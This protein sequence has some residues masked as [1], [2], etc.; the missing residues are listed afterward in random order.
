[1]KMNEPA[2]VHIEK[3]DADGKIWLEPALS[4]AYFRGFNS[5]EQND[6]IDITTTNLMNFIKKWYEHFPK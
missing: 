5:A 6:I 2:H 1:M 3:G 4:V